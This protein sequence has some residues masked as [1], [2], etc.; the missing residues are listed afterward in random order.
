MLLEPQRTS[1]DSVSEWPRDEVGEVSRGSDLC[2]PAWES[3]F[4]SNVDEG[5]A[6]S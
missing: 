2:K 6:I 1:V 3:S 4:Y 5:I